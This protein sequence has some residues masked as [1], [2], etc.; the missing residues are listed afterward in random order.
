M[1]RLSKYSIFIVFFILQ[2]ILK[3]FGNCKQIQIFDQI[4]E[5]T[6]KVSGEVSACN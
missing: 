3:H 5:L 1:S 6:L 2:S 4:K